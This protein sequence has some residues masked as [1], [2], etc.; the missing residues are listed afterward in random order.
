M[1]AL[2]MALRAKKATPSQIAAY[3]QE[4]RIWSVLRPYL[5]FA[6]ASRI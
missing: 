2:R 1:E 6:A 4:L 5:E 3:A